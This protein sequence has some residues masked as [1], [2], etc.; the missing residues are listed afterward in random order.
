MGACI[1]ERSERTLRYAAEERRGDSF[2]A[3]HRRASKLSGNR[4]EPARSD[5]WAEPVWKSE[6]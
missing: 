1:C 4:E 2:D 5:T 6:G 3:V